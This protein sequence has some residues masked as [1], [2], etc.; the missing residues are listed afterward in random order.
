MK[1]YTKI[2]LVTL[3]LI[4]ISLLAA[5]GTTYYFSHNAL[6]ELAE[7][8]LETRLSEAVRAAAEREEMLHRYSLEG[9][10]ASVKQAK[11]DAGAAM[12]SIEIGKRGYIFVVDSNGVIVMHPDKSMMG[13][14]VSRE[15]WF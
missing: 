15:S 14:D 10:A 1:I 3:P 13:K 4:I 12:L 7:T 8:W 6:T 11:L 9:M 2:L 5:V